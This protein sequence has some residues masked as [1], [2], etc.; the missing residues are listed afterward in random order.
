MIEEN[1]NGILYR[2]VKQETGEPVSIGDDI[3]NFRDEPDKIKNAVC[4]RHEASSG[5]VNGYFPH[6]YDLKWIICS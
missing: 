6:V 3:V 5:R 2:L 1:Y 4:P